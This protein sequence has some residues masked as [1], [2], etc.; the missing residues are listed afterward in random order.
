M[1]GRAGIGCCSKPTAPRARAL[2]SFEQGACTR[3]GTGPRTF[4][5]RRPRRIESVVLCELCELSLASFASFVPGA[6]CAPLRALR[7]VAALCAAVLTRVRANRWRMV[8]QRVIL[9]E[10]QWQGVASLET[11]A[12]AATVSTSTRS[13]SRRANRCSHSR[14]FVARL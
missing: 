5:L 2:A 8:T 6:L 4:E 9:T 11:A 10:V 13:R 12:V 3:G 7:A 14:T 1:N